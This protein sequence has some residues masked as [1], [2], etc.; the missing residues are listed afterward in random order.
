MKLICEA[1]AGAKMHV[2]GHDLEVDKNGLVE[3]PDCEKKEKEN[4]LKRLKIA[5]FKALKKDQNAPV[6]DTPPEDETP[7]DETPTEPSE[8]KPKFMRGGKGNK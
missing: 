1:H 7:P 4:V 5:G 6:D 2:A 8:D 3:V